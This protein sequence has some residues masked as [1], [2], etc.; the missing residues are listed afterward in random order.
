MV[1]RKPAITVFSCRY[2]GHVPVEMAGAHRLQYPASVTVRQVP[3]TGTIG[4]GH[5]LRELENGADGV[6]IVACPENNC[7]HLSGNERAARRVSAAKK[8]L[9]EAGLESER[10]NLVR[11]GVGSGR[12]FA[13]AAA[14]MTA[15]I[16]EIGPASQGG[17][18]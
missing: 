7:H 1:D 6:L 9:S 5:L 4:V 12:T 3:C 18:R 13:D 16:R 15:R 17:E 14:E 10:L 2:C 8:L 11:L